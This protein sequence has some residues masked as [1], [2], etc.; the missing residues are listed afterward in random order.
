MAFGELKVVGL[1][2]ALH[3]VDGTARNWQRFG[4]A[5]LC[6]HLLNLTRERGNILLLSTCFAATADRKR[7]NQADQEH[8][9]PHRMASRYRKPPN[10][11]PG[12]GSSKARCNANGVA[13]VLPPDRRASGA[14]ITLTGSPWTRPLFACLLLR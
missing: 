10:V 4:H 5:A 3:Q 8:S 6:H 9:A 11:R 7:R 2:F 1:A 12:F 14:A 13:A